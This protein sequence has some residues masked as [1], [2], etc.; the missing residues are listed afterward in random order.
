ME[1]VVF[2]IDNCGD[3]HTLAKFTR[4]LDTQRALTDLPGGVAIAV[5]EWEGKGEISFNL[6]LSDYNKH[7]KNS[8]YVDNQ[9]CIL[10]VPT[11]SKQPL[12]LLYPDGK[13]VKTEDNGSTKYILPEQQP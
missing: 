4:H 10:L 12:F 2:S 1:R 9:E 11:L 6:S 5:G 13:L 7:V 8:G 3:I